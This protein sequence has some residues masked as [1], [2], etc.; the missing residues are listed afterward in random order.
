M[1]LTNV[2]RLHSEVFSLSSTSAAP[3]L[4]TI[5]P[6][7]PTPHIAA[8]TAFSIN[9]TQDDL[10]VDV[11]GLRSTSP[12]PPIRLTF[13]ETHGRHGTQDSTPFSPS[14]DHRFSL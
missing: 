13:P 10:V 9:T 7:W 4:F 1:Y 2:R 5:D 8:W 6:H 12:P 3:I 11:G 14:L